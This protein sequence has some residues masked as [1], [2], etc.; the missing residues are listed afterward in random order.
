[1]SCFPIR[2]DKEGK[3]I[4][5]IACYDVQGCPF[6]Q[7]MVES[8]FSPSFPYT[9]TPLSILSKIQLRG[10]RIERCKWDP[11]ASAFYAVQTRKPRLVKTIFR[12][13]GTTFSR[14]L[15]I[16]PICS[17]PLMGRTSLQVSKVVASGPR[18]GRK[19]T[20]LHSTG[21]AKNGATDSWP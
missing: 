5:T 21:W 2:H 13:S 3:R 10:L 16:V 18:A 6:P 19:S 17:D 20:S 15:Y 11:E 9:V 4:V 8:D 7:N 14:W 1:M 12:H